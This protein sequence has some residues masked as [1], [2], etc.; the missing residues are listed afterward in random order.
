M[1]HID[2]YL[3]SRDGWEYHIWTSSPHTQDALELRVSRWRT[4]GGDD[5]QV[6]TAEGW[7][8]AVGG[9]YVDPMVEIR[10]PREIDGPLQE[11]ADIIRTMLAGLPFMESSGA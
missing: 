3:A 5:Y 9:A 6:L 1:R 7:V 11:A 4:R 2:A 10:A 8:D